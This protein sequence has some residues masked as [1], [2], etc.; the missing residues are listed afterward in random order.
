MLFRSAANFDGVSIARTARR[1]KLPSEASKRFERGVDPKVAEFAAERVT[2]LLVEL[3]GATADTLGSIYDET[4]ESEPISLPISFA[5]TLTGVNYSEAQIISS[6]ES[7]GCRVNKQSDELLVTPP[8]W[9]PDLQHKTDL[10]EEIARL[11]GYD[12]IPARLPVAPPGR[13]L[14]KDRKSTRLNSS[15]T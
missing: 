6:L 10:V 4:K 5:E 9:R 3:A 7:I 14:T 15:H 11:Q 8:S 13:G 2:Q 12:L 1:H